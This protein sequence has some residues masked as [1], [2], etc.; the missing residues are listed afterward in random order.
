MHFVYDIHAVLYG[1]RR[2]ISLLA[3]ISD[4]VNTVILRGVYFDDVQNRAVVYTAAGGTFSARIAVHGIFTVNRFCENFGT[5]GFA[6]SAR[7]G[8]KIGV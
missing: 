4:I 5:G 7:T 8:E 2:I 6:R 3:E 1:G